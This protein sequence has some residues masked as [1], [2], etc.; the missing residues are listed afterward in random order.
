LFQLR[1]FRSNP[2]AATYPRRLARKA[3]P[4][5]LVVILVSLAAALSAFASP[6]D[7]TL[8]SVDSAGNQGN[9]TS[10]APALNADGRYVAF[11]SDASNLVPGDTNGLY[12]AFVRDRQA[13]TTERVSVDS[14]GNES[15]GSSGP[16]SISADGRYVA[17]SSTASNL[18]PDDTNGTT[19]VFVHDLQTGATERVS[20]DS[21]GNE[22]DSYSNT[23]GFTAAALSADGRF[24]VFGSDSDNLV[25]GDTNGQTDA[26]VHD[27]QTGSTERVSVDGSGNEG[28]SG[29]VDPAISP[30]GRY[31][32]FGSYAT[33]LSDGTDGFGDLF[34]HDRQTGATQQ[35]DL[36]PG[37][38]SA[39][40][41]GGVGTGC[42]VGSF[43]ADN[44]Y[45]AF[46]SRSPNLVPRDN[47]DEDAFV[48]DLQTGATERVSVDSAGNQASG[49]GHLQGASISADGRYVAFK[50]QT[51][52]LVPDDT[53]NS[54]W[55]AFVHDRQTG[56]T[57]RVDV[58]SAGNPPDGFAADPVMS[59]DG[60]YVAFDSNAT[61]LVA[62][63]TNGVYDIFLHE[64]GE[65]PPPVNSVSGRT[66]G[67]GGT[68]STNSSTSS[69]DPL[70]TS[71]T[72]PTDG[73]VKIDEGATTTGD[74]AGYNLL[75]QEVQITAPAADP[76]DP[77]VIEFRIDAS[78]LPPGA[79]QTNVQVFRDGTVMADCDAGA[80][81]SATPDPCV[82]GRAATANGIA[83]TVRTSQAS[84]WNF[85]VSSADTTPP[86]TTIDSGP[87][88][89]T[90]DST[91]TFT[92][93][94]SEPSSSFKCRV[95]GGAFSACTSPK[96][97]ATLADGSH[98]FR[99]R[100]T[101]T[102]GNTDQ[103]P[104]VR[105]FT[106][107]THAPDTTITA[108]PSGP[109]DD[110]TPTF[111]F[112]SSQAG[113]SFAC[114]V[115]GAAFSPCSSPITLAALADGSH[116]VRVRATDAAGN[117]DTT[118]AVRTFT[119]DTQAPNTTITSGPSGNTTDRTPTF[120]FS[121][122]E[123]TGATFQCRLDS[124]AFSACSSP[125]TYST[126]AF[127]SHTFRVRA[128][129]AAGNADPS[130]ATRNFTVTR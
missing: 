120:R 92:F 80:G 82:A 53:T 10:S 34:V 51:P 79:N 7:T 22:G 38:A 45:V 114:R 110:S 122:S 49:F 89:A 40:S 103:T 67:G 116:T 118:P 43:S 77:L 109:T 70:G 97:L 69:G 35:I 126:L 96:T 52:F 61:N 5:L 129:D 98:T 59:A 55:D 75:G 27:R 15:N 39:G 73:T 95:D 14:A 83:L 26:F 33:N 127:G 11:V 121:S 48:R 25:S 78:L 21:A 63:D 124:A 87:T 64:L 112:A 20:V 12:D 24:V 23:A 8:V 102:A 84:T 28:N 37:G 47:N 100:A 32:G 91:P 123:P 36:T 93:S 13:G 94:S 16:I 54:S 9:G 50:S 62:G 88:S 81:T 72:T 3:A 128:I 113:S 17:F 117:T 44:R 56:V 29:S 42:N 57:E 115:D 41:C 111:R 19:D 1:Q 104:A 108:G 58:D 4:A 85:G 6:G 101:D 130:P 31:V 2:P 86:E 125:K 65:A 30:D 90:N 105:T 60:H 18:V 68:V 119:V 106:V 107:D 76:S 74:P 66:V 46:W 71:V 99:V